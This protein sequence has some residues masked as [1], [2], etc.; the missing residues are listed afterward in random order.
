MPKSLDVIRVPSRAGGD[1]LSGNVSGMSSSSTGYRIPK[2]WGRKH[3]RRENDETHEKDTIMYIGEGKLAG[4][5][6]I[7]K[8]SPGKSDHMK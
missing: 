1:F 3:P 8:V 2:V 5:V 4:D 6:V 7:A